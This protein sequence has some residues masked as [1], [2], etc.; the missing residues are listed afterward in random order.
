MNL[1]F[2]EKFPERMGG[3]KTYFIEKIFE[4]FVKNKLIPDGYYN[5]WYDKIEAHGV[6]LN[7]KCTPK[8][9]TIRKGNRWKV[10][11]KI[12]FC[13]G[14]RTKN[15]FRFAPVMEV[16]KVQ[17]IKINHYDDGAIFVHI[18]GNYFGYEDFEKVAINDG[19]ES[20]EQFIEYF[21]KDFEGQIVHWTN[22]KY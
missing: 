19:F 8:L 21:N 2:S 10:G 16:K 7:V 4:G 5:Y 9:H 17:K 15:Y 14:L 18:D 13:I 12:H 6:D 20:N 1:S 22:L 3:G 11:D